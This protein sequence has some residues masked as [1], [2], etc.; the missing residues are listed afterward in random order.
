MNM[1]SLGRKLFKDMIN[2][3][4]GDAAVTVTVRFIDASAYDPVTGTDTQT[5]VSETVKGFFAHASDEE[6]REYGVSE[7]TGRFSWPIGTLQ[8]RV[9]TNQD[10]VVMDGATYRVTGVSFDAAGVRQ[11][12]WVSAA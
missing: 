6:K 4:A 9:P 8:H 3:H 1:Q 10:E 11:T 12:L 5:V 7:A 2:L